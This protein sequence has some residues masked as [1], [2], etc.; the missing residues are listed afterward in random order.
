MPTD[1]QDVK[2]YYDKF[3]VDRMVNYRLTGNKRIEAAIAFIREYIKPTNVVVDIGCGIGIATEAAAK[4]ATQGQVV[5]VDISKENIRYASQTVSL[6][7]ISFQCLDVIGER[8]RLSGLLSRKPI[9][10]FI[11]I[12]VI[13]H[14][15][16]D[17][18]HEIFKTMSEMGAGDLT[19]L[20]T[21]PSPYY[22]IYL[23]EY[24][25][26]ELQVIDNVVTI[27]R[28]TQ[29]AA[30]YGLE[31]AFYALKDIWRPA[32]YVHCALRRSK[33][34]QDGIGRKI[35]K[36]DLHT[37]LHRWINRLLVPIRRHKYVTKVFGRL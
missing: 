18:R 7:N 24:E 13:E 8:D 33:S 19:I 30:Q 4:Q 29:E 16:D 9:D 22:Q 20:L 11:L 35:V 25:P 2:S 21:Y 12:D 23:K 10:V 37:R 36:R 1:T 5:G 34:L 26:Q 27:E 17:T 6:P 28:L 31:V 3:L 15:P 32:Q 14:L